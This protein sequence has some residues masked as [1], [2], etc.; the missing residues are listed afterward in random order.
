MFCVRIN[1]IKVFNNREGFLRLFNRAE[2]HIYSYVTAS[3]VPSAVEPGSAPSLQQPSLAI[4]AGEQIPDALNIQLWVIESDE[5]IR[6]FAPDADRRRNSRHAAAGNLFRADRRN[7]KKS[8]DPMNGNNP[9]PAVPP[10]TGRRPV[11]TRCLASLQGMG[12]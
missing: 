5:D 12:R 11:E 10:T 8:A 4:Y 9:N 3:S 2:M 6:R 1:K 7:G